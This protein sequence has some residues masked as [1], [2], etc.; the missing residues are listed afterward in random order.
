VTESFLIRATHASRSQVRDALR[1][2]A[3]DGLV[4]LEAGRGAIVPALTVE[5]VLEAYAVRHSLGSL[6]VDSATSW[7]PGTLRPLLKALDDLKSVASSGDSQATGES[8]L[9]FQDVLAAT[10]RLRRVPTMFRRMTM[11]VR[12]F[13]SLMGL[14]YT[15]SIEDIV[16]DDTALL[17][18]VR[19]RD[20]AR[21]RGLWEQKMDAAADYMIRQLEHRPFR[22]KD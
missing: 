10:A 12:L 8:D 16:T 3:A 14:E 20:A 11:Q 17:D 19:R 5:D 1:S 7:R 18:A 9:D 21:A 15:Y 4:D 22:R 13:T 6:I 2:L